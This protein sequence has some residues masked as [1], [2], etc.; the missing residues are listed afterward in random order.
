LKYINYIIPDVERPK[1]YLSLKERLYYTLIA[2]C[3]YFL[4][5]ATPVY[6]ISKQTASRFEAILILLGA[7]HGS[8][9]TL[10]I[11][12]IVTGVI[13]LELLV[14]AGIL[15]LDLNKE[16]DRKKFRLL[17]KWFS[18]LFIIL[19]NT[20][21]VINGML[22]PERPTAF[23]YGI[24][25]LQLIVGC[26]LL[27]ILDDFV[28]NWG[29]GS[30]ISL[31]ILAGVSAQ[32]FTQMF[33]FL[34]GPRGLPGGSF[35][36]GII[37]GIKGFALQALFS[38]MPFIAFIIILLLSVYTQGVRVE[39]PLTFGRLRG[40]SLTWPI[41]FLYTSNIP[42]IFAAALLA[43]MRIWALS[44]YNA[45]YPILGTF[46]RTLLP[47]GG[48]TDVPVS[49]VMYYLTPTPFYDAIIGRI[50]WSAWILK[51]LCYFAF[52]GIVCMLFAKLWI[53]IAPG[54]SPESVAGMIL[55][56]YLRIPGFRQEKKI[57]EKTISRYINAVAILG[58]L[59]VGFL[60][61][62]ADILGA[63]VRGTSI[64]LAAI[65]V[66]NYYEVIKRRYRKEIPKSV[67]KFLGI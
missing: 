28:D 22:A 44:L 15:P 65:I 62:L 6:G 10:G 41:S 42:V 19:E 32:I 53:M 63:P 38:F 24:V 11:G 4:L 5:S 2:L 34:P 33:S 14:G 48:Y 45:G 52:M 66:L 17:S 47:T 67:K 37:F 3:L 18:L 43:N 59:F 64:L 35:L 58:G 23:M 51:T 39:I 1:K 21:W 26:I 29:I 36:R 56:S 40:Y 57:V 12:P 20:I 25:I 16:E 7:V 31:F 8:L 46:N 60:A 61:A 50:S 54:Q 30:G 55:S 13:V 9:I 27:M 49:G